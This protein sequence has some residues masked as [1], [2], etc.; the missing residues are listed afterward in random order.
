LTKTENLQK[1]KYKGAYLMSN[2]LTAYEG[3]LQAAQKEKALI[4]AFTG[5]K[6]KIYLGASRE[7]E[8]W[9]EERRDQFLHQTLIEIAHDEKLKPCFESP[10]GKISVMKAVQRA[11]RTGLVIGG[12][13]AYLVP[14]GENVAGKGQPD[15]WVTKARFSIRDRGYH[16]LLCGGSRPIFRDLRW[17]QVYE[18]D[19]C[20][21]DE[22]TGEVKHVRQIGKSNGDFLGVWVQAIKMNGNK[23]AKFFPE[24][25]ISQWRKAAKNDAVWKQWFE[26]MALQASIRHFCD[27]YEV[28]RDLLASA[29]YDEDSV[30]E[31]EKPNTE[32]IDDS[33]SGPEIEEEIIDAV[34]GDA[35]IGKDDID[36]DDKTPVETEDPIDE[37]SLF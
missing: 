35:S 3:V 23:E 15:R 25:K 9:S 12:V 28:A 22:G 34:G 31:P 24:S 8:A 1:I 29:I 13:H 6:D 14:Q 27:R 18:G 5:I 33:L 30:V 36:G 37:D 26:E 2:E 16:A 10:E 32:H 4:E 19:N 7:I 17:G 20:Q 11:A 21:V